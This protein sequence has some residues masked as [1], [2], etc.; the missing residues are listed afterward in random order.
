MSG[1][2]T[3]CGCCGCRIFVSRATKERLEAKGKLPMCIDCE[4]DTDYTPT[5][6]A[7]YTYIRN[8]DTH[9]M[10]LPIEALSGTI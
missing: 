6:R 5:S 1:Y 8:G 9:Q 2:E 7:N 4:E 3:K 10:R